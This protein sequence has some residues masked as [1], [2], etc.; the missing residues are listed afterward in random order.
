LNTINTIS[1]IS[2]SHLNDHLP[3]VIITVTY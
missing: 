2:S 1:H 3:A